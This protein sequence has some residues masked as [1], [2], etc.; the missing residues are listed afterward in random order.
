M[1][2]KIHRSLPATA[3]LPLLVAVAL[4]P[5]ASACEPGARA[6][7]RVLAA[8]RFQEAPPATDTPRGAVRDY[9]EACRAGDHERAARYLDLR[10]LPPGER[11]AQGPQLA[12]HLKVVLDRTLWIDLESLSAEAS[13]DLADGLAP[14]RERVGTLQARGGPFEIGLQRGEDERGQP[15]WR[16]AAGTVARI[17]ALYDEFGYGLLGEVLPERFFAV[18]FL[19]IQ[20]WQWIGLLLVVVG[21]YLLSWLATLVALALLRP[22]VART[23]SRLDDHL[24]G[25]MVKPLRFAVALA[26]IAAGLLPLRLAVPVHEFL[27]GL[28]KGLAVVALAWTCMR[29]VDLASG[30]LGERLRREGKSSAVAVLPLGEKTVKVVILALATTAM[31]QNLGFNVTGVLAGLGVGGLAVALAAQK[32]V[33]NLFGGMSLILDQPVRVGDFCRFGERVGTVEDVGLRTTKIRTLDR[34]VVSI[35]NADFAHM[36]L[37]NFA[38]RDKILF[39]TKLGLRYETSADQLRWVLAEIRRMFLA[40]PRVEPDPGRIRFVSY[41]DY[42]LDLEIFAF[43]NTPDFNEY[44]AIQEDLLL[45]IMDV[46]AA[47]GTGFAFPSS[48]TYLARDGGND[49]ERTRAAEGRVRAWREGGQLPFP[50]FAPEVKAEVDDTLDYPPRG[51]AVPAART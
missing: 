17:P 18:G 23:E 47:S 21:A 38:R 43:V 9:L 20:L 4:A 48:T 27:Q 25:L 42:S 1:S 45:R 16:F 24:L 50:D 3:C 19:E 31:L 2:T 35:P 12:R 13:G 26:L 6:G 32:T 46:V 8:L 37:E 33:E 28:L 51:S 11:A 34:T 36:P 7:A 49:P 29:L 39:K 14:D 5:R 41:G 15:L 30:M 44:L 10:A 22:L 40:H